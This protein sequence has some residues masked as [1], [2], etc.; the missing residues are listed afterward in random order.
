MTL[1]RYVGDVATESGVYEQW[2]ELGQETY[3]SAVCE[4]MET[5]LVT[6]VVDPTTQWAGFDLGVKRVYFL[7]VE[8]RP[9]YR[10]EVELLS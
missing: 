7:D 6:E 2:E 10:A 3:E 9:R 1:C 5:D 8:R 4:W